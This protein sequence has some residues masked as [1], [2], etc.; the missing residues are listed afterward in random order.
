MSRSIHQS[1]KHIF[2]AQQSECIVH[3]NRKHHD[4]KSTVTCGH[5]GRQGQFSVSWFVQKLKK[6]PRDRDKCNNTIKIQ[7]QAHKHTITN[8]KT[9]DNNSQQQ[10]IPWNSVDQWMTQYHSKLMRAWSQ[11]RTNKLELCVIGA[12]T[13]TNNLCQPDLIAK[14]SRNLCQQIDLRCR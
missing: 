13:D 10:Q 2:Q 12:T 9:N 4:G 11:V 1:P 8:R 7:S 5:F 6:S 14:R 3:G